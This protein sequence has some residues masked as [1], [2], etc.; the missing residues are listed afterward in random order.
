VEFLVAFPVVDLV[1]FLVAFPG[2]ALAS[3]LV[4]DLEVNPV[5][6]EFLGAVPVAVPVNLV[7]VLVNLVEGVVEFV[8]HEQAWLT[9]HSY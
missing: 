8:R 4:V 9:T 2:E 3:F 6:L 5:A 7:V 1:A